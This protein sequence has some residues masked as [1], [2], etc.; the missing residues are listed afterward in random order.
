MNL[1]QD[2]D[3][4]IFDSHLDPSI[5]VVVVHPNSENYDMLKSQF[6]KS[7]SAFL[8]HDLRVII[9]DGKVVN[10]PWFTFE[11]LLVIQA[12]EIG[13]F[14]AGHAV[15]N[16]SSSNIEKE[17]DW[18]GYMLLSSSGHKAAASLHKQEYYCRYNTTPHA[19]DALFRERLGQLI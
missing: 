1:P 7:G 17:A 13:H 11:H 10:E 12:H 15:S 3:T 18:L 9:I 14:L 4:V 8:L 19:D 2:K 5:Q 16:N 6:S